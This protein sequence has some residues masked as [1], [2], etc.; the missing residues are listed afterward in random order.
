MTQGRKWMVGCGVGCGLL[1]VGGL[2]ACVVGFLYLERTFSGVKRAGESYDAL[3]AELGP[4]DAFVPSPDGVPSPD[5]IELFLTVREATAG[6][7]V[8]AEEAMSRLSRPER[9]DTGDVVAQIQIGIA[10]LGD[11]VDRI[12]RYLQE[13]NE[14]L[15]ERRMGAGE[16]V[17]IYTL[18]YY[19][20]LGH[21]PGEGV[22]MQREGENVH[23]E[24]L[25]LFSGRAV[26]RRY[27]R[28]VLGMV[29]GQIA[30]LGREHEAGDGQ[31]WQAALEAQL[32]R[33]ELDPGH[34]LWDDGLPV[35][36]EASLRPF[37]ERLEAT[38][39]P[40]TNRIELPLAE[41]EV[42]EEWK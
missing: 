40:S 6:A 7:R 16:Y 15:L 37:R 14:A 42:P 32:R 39:S 11:L 27:R 36:I 9:N 38:Y 19:S 10:A 24:A 41:H 35:G 2:G 23:V 1:T 13:R 12:G 5:R 4:V 18:A 33:L 30:S 28:Y 8:E 29:R 20:W 17:Y 31:K 3:V 26:R 25:D 34:V 22:E 21:T